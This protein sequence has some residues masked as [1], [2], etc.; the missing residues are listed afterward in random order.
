MASHVFLDRHYGGLNMEHKIPAGQFKAECLKLMD[1]VKSKHASFI[2]TKHG[3]PIA[4]LV[5]V[6]DTNPIDLFGALKGTIKIKGDIISSIDE[7]W[8]AEQ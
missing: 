6:E 2:I 8:D 4:K 7:E 5:P 3:I 1:Y